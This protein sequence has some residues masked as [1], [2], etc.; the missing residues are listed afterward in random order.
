MSKKSF[1]GLAMNWLKCILMIKTLFRLLIP[2]GFVKIE[3]NLV[4]W[5]VIDTL[6]MVVFIR[7]VKVSITQGKKVIGMTCCILRRECLVNSR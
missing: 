3:H 7:V 4:P 2:T 6:T 5:I 1:C